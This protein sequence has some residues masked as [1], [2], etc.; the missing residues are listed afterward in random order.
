MKTPSLTFL[1]CLLTYG[2][3]QAQ[4]YEIGL[5]GGFPRVSHGGLG[6]VSVVGGLDTD[7]TIHG[8][9][10]V[11][12]WITYDTNG[13]YGHEI[14]FMDSPIDVTAILRA[15]VNGV[16]E[17]ETVK[18]R[19]WLPQINYNF[20]VYFMPKGERWRPF[21]TG[22]IQANQYPEPNIPNWTSGHTKHYGLNWGGGVKL[23]LFPHA[24]ARLDLRDYIGGKPYDLPLFPGGLMHQLEATLGVGV[25]F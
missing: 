12:A 25:T 21:V 19:V 23:K 8:S 22:G 1:F 18:D 16:T 7:T 9:Y 4:T 20:L 14:S 11:G 3:A 17:S 10:S 13:Y 6:S 24:L 2:A 15:T 5:F